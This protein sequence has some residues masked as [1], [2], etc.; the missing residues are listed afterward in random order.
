MIL[1]RKYYLDNSV[2]YRYY[3]D[4]YQKGGEQYA[5]SK[6]EN[7]GNFDLKSRG[8]RPASGAGKRGGAHIGRL[9]P[10]GVERISSQSG[11]RKSRRIT[12]GGT[13]PEWSAVPPH[14]H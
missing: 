9:Y 10:L 7:A 13:A 11:R 6:R 14:G 12:C 1:Y 8:A 2:I 4:R 3:I 5:G